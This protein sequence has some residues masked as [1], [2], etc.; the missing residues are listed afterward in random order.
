MMAQTVL[1]HVLVALPFALLLY[2]YAGYPIALGAAL[3]I[4]G[5]R[6]PSATPQAP[7]D[8]RRWPSVA[9]VVV[10]YNE[11]RAIRATVERLLGLDYPSGRLTIVVVSDGSTDGTSEIVRSFAPRGVR[12]IGLP[13]RRGKAAAENSAREFVRADIIVN[14]DATIRV[15]PNAL[16]P[17]IRAFDDPTV[18]VASG[19]DLSEGDSVTEG[20][21][22]ESGYVGYEM[23]VRSLETRLGSIVGASGCFYAIRG[24]L[25]E[26]WIAEELCHRDF[27]SVLIARQ[28]G[29][30]SVS[31]G[32]ALCVVPRTP[33][34]RAEYR[35]KARTMALGLQTLWYHRGLLNPL[36]HG[37]FAVM[38]FS[39]K[40]CRWLV[41]LFMP[42]AL[43]AL[44]FASVASDLALYTV[45]A[46]GAM[47]LLGIVGLGWPQGRAVPALFSFPAYLLASN[48][49][50]VV[51][52]KRV[53]GRELRPT[54]EPT[55]RVT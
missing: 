14:V 31:V 49:A 5:R 50:G 37:A 10:C 21:Q 48:A 11:E 18:G 44:A 15:L 19:C 33:A 17:L 16:K 36:R 28:S 1:L 3:W 12:H 8:E 25:Y 29:F 24:S 34:V 9:I 27:A 45:V 47:T 41:S 55:R 46:L 39:H 52:W 51:A 20:N 2:A 6:R 23:W 42:V 22:A 13:V 53:F 4:T 54:W 40:L 26:H 38:L 32:E 43:G 35:R 7:N 30:R